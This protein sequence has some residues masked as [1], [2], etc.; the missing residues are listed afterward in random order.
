MMSD[1]ARD[2]EL[3]VKAAF[4]LCGGYGVALSV[5]EEGAAVLT[6][7]HLPI[8]MGRRW[9]LMLLQCEH[10]TTSDD[11][12]GWLTFRRQGLSRFR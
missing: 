7:H 12:R 11:H 1:S 8:L 9:T 2:T 3:A 10:T 5:T 6:E 4:I